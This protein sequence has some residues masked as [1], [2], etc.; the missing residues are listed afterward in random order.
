MDL[1]TQQAQE[2]VM[3]DRDAV[4]TDTRTIR[5]WRRV[6]A[7]HGGLVV[8]AV[9]VWV[10]VLFQWRDKAWIAAA[11]L[12][13][14]VGA[15]VVL[16]LAWWK[17]SRGAPVV[18]PGARSPSEL[19]RWSGVRTIVHVLVGLAVAAVL[20][21]TIVVEKESFL[22]VGLVIF[23]A[24]AIH[25]G[26]VWLAAVGD[27]ESEELERLGSRRTGAPKRPSPPETR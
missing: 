13:G 16:H 7:V 17:A 22:L 10:L 4:Q 18:A 15:G 6:R 25:G 26:P 21:T 5:R 3:S 20:L 14:L 12:C 2:C 24:I 23:L 8:A 11:M 27:E 1:A 19:V 9:A